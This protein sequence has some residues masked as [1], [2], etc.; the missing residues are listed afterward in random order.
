[1]NNAA[2]ITQISFRIYQKFHQNFTVKTCWLVLVSLLIK[3]FK[4]FGYRP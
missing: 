2:Y 4:Y 3:T 1:M